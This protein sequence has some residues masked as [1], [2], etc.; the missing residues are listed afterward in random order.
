M[1]Q[2]QRTQKAC[3][4]FFLFVAIVAACVFV[5]ELSRG[6]LQSAL[7]VIPGAI[8]TLILGLW[9]L[10]VPKSDIADEPGPHAGFAMAGAPVPA[11]SG[12]K[13]RFVAGKELP[14]SDVTRSWPKD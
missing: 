2:W 10:K 1:Q 13:H 8:V 4:R 3:A 12:P 6:D 5:A 14:P 7:A 9:G 11:G